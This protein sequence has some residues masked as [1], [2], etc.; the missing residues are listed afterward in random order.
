M[1][2]KRPE[3]GEEPEQIT[4]DVKD[5][6][7]GTTISIDTVISP[8]KMTYEETMSCFDRAYDELLDILQKDNDSLDNIVMSIQFP[9]SLCNGIVNIHIYPE[10]YRIIDYDGTVYNE[11]IGAGESVETAL[12]YVMSYEDYTRNGVIDI[13]V[14]SLGENP[15]SMLTTDKQTLKRI[16]DNALNEN[17]DKAVIELPDTINNTSV[18]YA[19]VQSQTGSKNNLLFAAMIAIAVI[20]LI[21]YKKKTKA[22]EEQKLRQKQLQYD[23]SEV[24]SKLTLL[25]GAG[26]TVRRAWEKMIEDYMRKKKSAKDERIVYEQMYI[27]DCQIKSGISE[28]KAYEEFGHRC[29]TREYLKLA[30]LLQTNIKKGTKELKELLYQESY[31]AFE[32]RKSLAVK[33][34][35]EAATRL[36]MPM[37]ML[38]IVVMI[39]VM[40]PAVISFQV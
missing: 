8:R 19:Y 23:Y 14:K 29:Q 21:Y 34:G 12:N 16:I 38:L 27:T 5:E 25:L 40:V 9:D 35:E 32:Q 13:N 4:L 33:K 1:E 39:I 7:S 18:T 10:D 37:F 2:I 22:K 15:Y 28:Y 36:L 26:M 24:I 30:S 17:E 31:D 20:V 6:N 3:P 11:N